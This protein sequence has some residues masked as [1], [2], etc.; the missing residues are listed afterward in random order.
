M[1][2]L[3]VPLM[4]IKIVVTERQYHQQLVEQ[5]LTESSAGTQ[6]ITTPLLVIPYIEREIVKSIDGNGKIFN[7]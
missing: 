2:L 6:R 5:T 3:L 7:K 4:L 1:L